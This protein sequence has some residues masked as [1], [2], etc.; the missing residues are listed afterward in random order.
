MPGAMDVCIGATTSSNGEMVADT[1]FCK[2]TE[3]RLLLRALGGNP[4]AHVLHHFPLDRGSWIVKVWVE[5]VAK[6]E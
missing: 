3:N 1:I 6:F 5:P 2:A 4:L